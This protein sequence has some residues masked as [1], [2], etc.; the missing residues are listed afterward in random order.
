M[1]LPLGRYTAESSKTV[2]GETIYQ[3]LAANNSRNK[4]SVRDG[5]RTEGSNK[6]IEKEKNVSGGTYIQNGIDKALGEFLKT[7]TVIPDGEVQAGAT[8]TPI[9][10]LMS[11]GNPTAG[12]NS[13]NSIG[14]SN[15]GDGT[16]PNDTLGDVLGFVTQ[17]TATYAKDAVDNHYVATTPLF[18]TLGLGVSS[19]STAAAVLNPSGYKDSYGSIDEHW[20]NY[21]NTTDGNSLVLAVEDGKNLPPLL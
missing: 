5:V 15:L 2:D 10:V 3:F 4:V 7:D 18:Y 17:L 21:L 9:F 19:E 11:D 1:L 14:T 8:R 13:F 20:E 6:K 16:T 12:T